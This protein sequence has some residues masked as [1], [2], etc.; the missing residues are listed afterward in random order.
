MI[1]LAGNREC[2]S[3]IKTELTQ[4]KISIVNVWR[5][6]SEVPASIIGV[7]NGFKFMRAWS[8]WIMTGYMPLK[9]AEI[10]YEYT[11]NLGVRAFGDAGNINPKYSNQLISKEYEKKVDTILNA[12]GTEYLINHAKEL[13]EEL[14]NTDKSKLYVKTY[15]IDTQEG[16]NA[17][18]EFIRKN[19][20]KT[21]LQ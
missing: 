17:I 3:I 18:S 15:H 10:I 4:S 1:N 13:E 14:L 20:I 5:M 21:K 19:N 16:L 12:Y 8:Y 11:R 6:N 9:Q 2:D 7:L